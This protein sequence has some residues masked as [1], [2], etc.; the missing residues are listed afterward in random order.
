MASIGARLYMEVQMTKFHMYRACAALSALAAVV[1]A[2]GAG[3][4]F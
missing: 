3:S 1:V 2:S 4:K